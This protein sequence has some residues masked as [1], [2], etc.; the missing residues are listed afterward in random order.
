M[1]RHK[2]TLDAL[3]STKNDSH[4]ARA[5]MPNPKMPSAARAGLITV[6]LIIT[7]TDG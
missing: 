7:T 2:S 5:R 1:R 6:A 3:T 4:P